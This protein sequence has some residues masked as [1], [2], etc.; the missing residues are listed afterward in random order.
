[1]G[2]KSGYFVRTF[3]LLSI[4]GFILCLG[5]I[6]STIVM[7]IVLGSSPSI[8]SIYWQRLFVSKIVFVLIIPG[9]ILIVVSALILSWKQ[10]GFFCRKWITI[11]QLFIVLIIINSINITLLVDKVT[12]I[13]IRQH[14]TM[15]A[16]PEYGL[17]K[18]REDMFGAFNMIMLLGCLIIAIYLPQDK[19]T[20]GFINSVSQKC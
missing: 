10:Y 17:L 19:K 5:S 13:A 20:L 18:S 14:Q 6:F 12:A 2:N 11:A 7:N 3:Q 16:I 8:D 15:T 1:M 9:I 4:L